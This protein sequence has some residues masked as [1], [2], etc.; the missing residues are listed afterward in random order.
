MNKEETTQKE[1][2]LQ[3]EVE[4]ASIKGDNIKNAVE[5]MLLKISRLQKVVE[6]VYNTLPKIQIDKDTTPKEK[7]L[8]IG[9]IIQGL[10]ANIKE[11]EVKQQPGTPIEDIA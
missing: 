6:E 4:E 10:H 2:K 7:V 5:E 9:K 3:K 1:E 11:L 8:N